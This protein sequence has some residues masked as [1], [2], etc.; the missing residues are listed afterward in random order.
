M[1]SLLFLARSL[2]P[3]WRRPLRHRRPCPFVFEER[4]AEKG[5]RG[6]GTGLRR[7]GAP[8]LGWPC[9][10]REMKQNLFFC[11]SLL[12]VSTL[13]LQ[14][15]LN[16]LSTLHPQRLLQPLQLQLPIGD[17]MF[18][19]LSGSGGGALPSSPC[20][21]AASVSASFRPLELGPDSRH[22]LGA[23]GAAGPATTSSAGSPRGH[24]QKRAIQMERLGAQQEVLEVE[25]EGWRRSRSGRARRH[26]KELE[27]NSVLTLRSPALSPF[28]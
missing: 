4:D 22:E 1:A 23:R 24:S 6:G 19:S 25:A 15:P 17:R 26:R 7:R 11:D 14:P 10:R 8:M 12:V 20:F 18:D 9:P 2:A 3:C 5:A 27:S 21:S 16:F 28:S 13:H